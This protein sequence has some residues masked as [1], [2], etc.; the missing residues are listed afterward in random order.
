MLK[1]GWGRGELKAGAQ[2]GWFVCLHANLNLDRIPVHYMK[3]HTHA[4]KLL[5]M[6]LRGF[7][8]D[9]ECFLEDRK[10][11][12]QAGP[13]SIEGLVYN[14]LLF[15]IFP[16]RLAVGNTLH[17]MHYS[18]SPIFSTFYFLLS[19]FYVC[20]HVC[21]YVSSYLSDICC[22]MVARRGDVASLRGSGYLSRVRI[23]TTGPHMRNNTNTIPQQQRFPPI[24]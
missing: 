3:T 24:L 1:R 5:E 17:V 6:Q 12:C 4:Y 21:R 23:V 9:I 22:F 2:R 10:S 15:F 8:V 14:V 13:W 18:T 20:R 16:S 11:L 19:D 7:I